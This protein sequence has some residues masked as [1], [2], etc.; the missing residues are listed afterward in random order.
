MFTNVVLIIKF[1]PEASRS[2]AAQ[3]VTV[4]PTGWWVRSPLEEMKYLPKFIFPFFRSGVEAK[5]GVEFCHST[6]NA[7]RIRQ[8]VGNEVS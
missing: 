2:A 8:K 4:K 1:E 3:S 5:C 7:S 6:R